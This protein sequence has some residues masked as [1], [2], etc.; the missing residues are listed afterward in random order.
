MRDLVCLLGHVVVCAV[1]LGYVHNMRTLL[2]TM[3]DPRFS[4]GYAKDD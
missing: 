3:A 2:Q 4:E 1:V